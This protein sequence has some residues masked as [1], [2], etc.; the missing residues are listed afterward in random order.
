MDIESAVEAFLKLWAGR[1]HPDFEPTG[2]LSDAVED[3][4]RALGSEDIAPLVGQLVRQERLSL[5][6]GSALLA[7]ATWCGQENGAALHRTLDQWLREGSD[8]QRISLAL[9][10]SVFPFID[11]AEMDKVLTQIAERFPEHAAQCRYLIV[12]RPR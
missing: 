5:H 7:V 11:A 3:L 4:F 8:S 12:N 6:A 9:T 1:D 10:H 2:A